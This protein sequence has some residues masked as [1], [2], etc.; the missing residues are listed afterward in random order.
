VDADVRSHAQCA[1]HFFVLHEPADEVTRLGEQCGEMIRSYAGMPETYM[2]QIGDLSLG[3][4]WKH[5]DIPVLVIYGTADPATSADEGRYLAGL[6]N[7]FHPGRA[8]YVELEGMGHD[9]GRYGSQAE[10]LKRQVDSGT[11]PF[12]AEVASVVLTWLDETRANGKR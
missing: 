6:I 8:S 3:N 11:H 9:F 7:S 1:Y 5:V 12:D 4:Q 10:F 2:H